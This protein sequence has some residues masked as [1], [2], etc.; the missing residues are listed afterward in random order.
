MAMALH[1]LTTNA[2]KYGA[3][4]T[5]AGEVRIEWRHG[6]NGRLAFRWAEAGGPAVKPPRRKGFGTSV[7]VGM[8]RDQL[9][10]EVRFEWDKEGLV[11][12]VDLPAEKLERLPEIPA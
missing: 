1:E 9:D 10:G 6:P 2:A 11:C 12:E 3:L 4:S 7:I 5:P 8:I